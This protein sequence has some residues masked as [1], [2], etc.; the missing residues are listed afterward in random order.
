[1]TV[2][3]NAVNISTVG[4]ASQLLFYWATNGTA[5]WHPET[6]AGPGSVA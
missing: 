4:T 6:I 3:G 1:M 2:N 5:T